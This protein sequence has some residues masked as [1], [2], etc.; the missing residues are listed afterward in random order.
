[1]EVGAALHGC[2]I[3]VA[4]TMTTTAPLLDC[5][6]SP[7]EVADP[8][9]APYSDCWTVV[10]NLAGLP[11][12]SVPSGRSAEDGIPIGTMLTGRAGSDFGLVRVAEAM[13]AAGVDA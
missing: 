6:T 10:A 3:L 9:T 4:P 7:E 1:M 11:S 5:A 2:E 13:E 12:I 8:L